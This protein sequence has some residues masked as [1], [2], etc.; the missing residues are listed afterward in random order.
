MRCSCNALFFLHA[1]TY[2]IIQSEFSRKFLKTVFAR[3]PPLASTARCG[4]HPLATPVVLSRL[5]AVLRRQKI[6]TR[7]LLHH[8][9]LLF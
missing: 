7:F 1:N 9:P 3:L 2:E 8:V 4:P 5:C 6:L